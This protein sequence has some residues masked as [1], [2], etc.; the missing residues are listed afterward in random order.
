MTEVSDSHRFLFLHN[1]QSELAQKMN[2]YE[3]KLAAVML[4]E[5]KFPLN[6]L[7]SSK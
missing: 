6:L 7:P 4:N 3:I 2:T 1:L 5:A